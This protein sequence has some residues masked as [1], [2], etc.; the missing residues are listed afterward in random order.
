MKS[1]YYHIYLTEDNSWTYIL[2]DQFKLLYDSGLAKKI[3]NIHVT[4]IG[5]EK[6]LDIFTGLLDYQT[7]IIGKDINAYL[8]EKPNDDSLLKD[9]N[10]AKN[11]LTETITLERIWNFSRESENNNQV[12]YFHSKGVTSI[13][14][15]LDKSDVDFG[16]NIFTNYYHWRKFLDWSTIEMHEECWDAL[17]L[18]DAAG[19]NFTTWPA[20][21]Y[22][23]NYWWANTDYIKTL[24]NPIEQEW[25]SEYRKNFP[26][27]LTDRIKD[28]LWI[29]SGYNPKMFSLMNHPS[30]P[31]KAS[32]AEVIIKRE[33]YT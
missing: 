14:R 16:Y 28:E 21:H 23:G 6:E 1:I 29:G 17:H 7:K 15:H 24:S 12:M 13:K 11:I 31:P 30:A 26:S 18:N 9:I 33:E 19:A 10:K 27:F 32:L 22:S 4:G 25:W 5:K 8:Y 2:L 20:P 3:D